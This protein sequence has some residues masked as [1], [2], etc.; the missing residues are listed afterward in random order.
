MKEIVFLVKAEAYAYLTLAVSPGVT[1]TDSYDIQL[2]MESNSKTVIYKHGA[3]SM[4][5]EVIQF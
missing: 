1:L 4:Q 5:V 2:G 3:A